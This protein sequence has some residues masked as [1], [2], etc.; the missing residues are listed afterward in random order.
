M[1]RVA[2]RKAGPDPRKWTRRNACADSRSR[3]GAVP[4]VRSIQS[5]VAGLTTEGGWKLEV[6]RRRRLWLWVSVLVAVTACT[7]SPPRAIA[8]DDADADGLPLPAEYEKSDEASSAI[9]TVSLNWS[10]VETGAATENNCPPGG[11]G[12]V[13]QWTDRPTA[14][15]VGDPDVR[16]YLCDVGNTDDASDVFAATPLE[17][18]VLVLT[19]TPDAVVTEGLG[20]AA[21]ESKMAC[22]RR[23]TDLQECSAWSYLGRYGTHLV[24]LTYESTVTRSNLNQDEFTRL[25]VA[26]DALVVAAL[27]ASSSQPSGSPGAAV[28]D[29]GAT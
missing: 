17:R 15:G 8:L 14:T 4:P 2:H 27:A 6:I 29:A 12:L 24:T 25:A 23:T 3:A 20:L 7:S 9:E 11:D 26:V 16:L 19:S 22:V 13:W 10:R 5:P 18:T 28:A 1:S 21:D